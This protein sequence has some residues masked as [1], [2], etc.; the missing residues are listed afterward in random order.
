MTAGAI[1][2]LVSLGSSS[3]FRPSP[4]TSTTTPA[5]R[6]AGL[7]SQ[8][9][10]STAPS[11]AELGKSYG[12]PMEFLWNPYGTSRPPRQGDRLANRLQHPQQPLHSSHQAGIGWLDHGTLVPAE[13]AKP[14]YFRFWI[15]LARA[16]NSPMS[17]AP[18][19]L[20]SY[21]QSSRSATGKFLVSNGATILARPMSIFGGNSEYTKM[22]LRSRSSSFWSSRPSPLASNRLKMARSWDSS[23]SCVEASVSR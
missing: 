13:P 5:R 8:D 20:M 16:F 12:I 10:L 3:A 6:S 1:V 15:S 23:W 9:R 2:L 22:S 4:K 19:R 7:R 14:F 17:N 18:S 21:C 11:T